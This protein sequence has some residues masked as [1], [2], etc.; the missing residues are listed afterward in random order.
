VSIALTPGERRR[1]GSEEGADH[2]SASPV[3]AGWRV[4]R[5]VCCPQA[6]VE[7]FRQ[8]GAVSTFDRM[9]RGRSASL[10]VVVCVLAAV[11]GCDGEAASQPTS[12][13]TSSGVPTGSS[14]SS[15]SPTGTTSPTS[16]SP[17]KSPAEQVT[18][19]PAARANTPAGAEAFVRFY[20]ELVNAAWTEPNPELLKPYVLSSCKTCANQ[21]ATAL[22]LRRSGQRY[23]DDPASV[24]PT[25][26]AP[27][28]GQSKAVIELP[29]DQKA[30]EIVDDNGAVVEHLPTIRSQS[31]VTVVWVGQR[32]TWAVSE[33]RLTPLP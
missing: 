18:V 9:I 19:P 6:A 27:E 16:T 14:A 20:L 30:A 12:S 26:V 25:V 28:T 11:A 13:A 1:A 7:G 33:I 8:S 23:S 32:S 31:Q 24:G 10:G 22:D 29:Y 2:R 15:T 4:W 21:I 5:W 3:C 17:T